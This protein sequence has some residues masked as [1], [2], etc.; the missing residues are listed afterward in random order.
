[1]HTCIIIQNIYLTIQG[2]IMKQ[3]HGMVSVAH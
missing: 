1:M 3:G 2:C